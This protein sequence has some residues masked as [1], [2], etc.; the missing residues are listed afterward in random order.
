[1]SAETS[2]RL[3]KRGNVRIT[4]HEARLRNSCCLEKND[5]YYIFV[6]VC[7]C[8]G[9]GAGGGGCVGVRLWAGRVLAW[10]R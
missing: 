6:S 8:G 2:T 1:M 10:R 7:V 3:N 5:R 4:Y 9:G